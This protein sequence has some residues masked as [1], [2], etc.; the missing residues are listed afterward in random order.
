LTRVTTLLL[1]GVLLIGTVGCL[2]AP[3]LR[4]ARDQAAALSASL[5]AQEEALVQR[6]AEPM[7]DAGRRQLQTD[8]AL[9]RAQRSALDAAIAQVDLALDPAPGADDPLSAVVSA[10][11]PWLPDHARLPLLLG[12][13]LGASLLRQL[14]V[15]RAAESIV[16]SVAK[17]ARQDP[18]FRDR[19]EANADTFRSIQ[20]PAAAALVD[21][22]Q[23]RAA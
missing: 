10:I 14:R 3:D 20:T 23:R 12:A 8:L 9:A 4:A 2:G 21:R 5:E 7:T 19:L 22:R 6:A 13:G 18:A 11:A 16:D 15:R 1:A 17:A